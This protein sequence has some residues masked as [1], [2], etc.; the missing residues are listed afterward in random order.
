MNVATCNNCGYRH[1][2]VTS[3]AAHE[4][5]ALSAKITTLNDLKIRVIKS[6]TAT[7]SIPEF[8]AAITPG[9][10]SEGYIS[11][12]EGVLERVEDAL[13]FMLGSVKGKKLVKGER[14]LKR[15]KTAKQRKPNFTL[16]LKDP[17]GNS[18]LVS[19]QP[20]KIRKRK[21]ARAELGK[22]KFGQYAFA[23]T[24]RSSFQEALP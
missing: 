4:P 11:N 24:Q 21:L 14:I 23:Q 19:P 16:V 22:L 9:P 8:G 10:H 1:T 7:I 15:I 3:L 18:A 2:D 13:M 5:V 17:L 20:S 12:V 6:A